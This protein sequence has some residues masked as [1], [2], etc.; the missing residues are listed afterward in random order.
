MGP[1]AGVRVGRSSGVGDCASGLAGP[2]A[3]EAN[4]EDNEILR[5]LLVRG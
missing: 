3:G 1:I 4:T 2:V 5:T